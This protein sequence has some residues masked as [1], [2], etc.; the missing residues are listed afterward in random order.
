MKNF[1]DLVSEVAE[2]KAPEE[3]RFKDQHAIEVIPHPVA[4]DHQFTGDIEGVTPTKL[5][6]DKADDTKDYDKAYKTKD[7]TG[8]K[9][10]SAES[11]RKSITEILGV[12]KKKDD[13]KDDEKP[14]EAVVLWMESDLQMKL[15]NQK[16]HRHHKHHPH[17]HNYLQEENSLL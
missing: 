17:H 9:L 3:K 13:K 4:L 8:A 2:P 1:K 16:K 6:A 7:D 12:N 10:E 14:K 15:H 5:P 11:N